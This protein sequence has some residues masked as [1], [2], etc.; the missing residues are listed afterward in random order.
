VGLVVHP[1]VTPVRVAGPDDP[2][3]APYRDL[4]DPALRRAAGLFAVESRLLVRRLLEG[5][6]FRVRSVLL[7]GAMLD[8][9]APLL[10]GVRDAAVLV[11]DHVTIRSVVGFDFHRGCMALAE[12]AA[13]PTLDAVLAAS[14]R[15][16]VIGEQLADHDN[17]GALLRNAWAFGADAVL[18]GPGSADPFSRKAIRVSAGAALAL[19]V[20][21]LA[22]RPAD[23]ARLRA[24]GLTVLA[25][26]AAPD[27]VP[28]DALGRER[29][30]PPRVAVLVGNEG[31]GLSPGA[32]AA[33]D[34][35]VT[36]PMRPGVDSLNVAVATGIALHH[37]A[38][39]R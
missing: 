2:R 37:L 17:V 4:R 5:G 26:V 39:R 19:P 24:A 6:R 1:A 33:A 25:L 35:A 38:S 15:L 14:P 12:R 20:V 13:G 11:A 29:P 22:D 18:L 34:V 27:A 28:L 21:A 10:A 36:I 31:D 30:L 16:V 3:L 7:T 23:L 9:L 8:D 32:V